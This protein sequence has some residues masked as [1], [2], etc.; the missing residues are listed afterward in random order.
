MRTILTTASAVLVFVLGLEAADIPFCKQTANYTM[1]VSL[2]TE[3]KTITAAEFIT[4]TNDTDQSTDEL[5][6]HLYW[7]AFQ[8]NQSTFVRESLN[9]GRRMPDLSQDDWGYCLVKSIKLHQGAVNEVHDLRPTLSFRHPDDDNTLDQTVFSVRLPTPVEPGQTVQIEIEFE[10]KIPKPFSRTGVYKE[11]YFI[12]QWFPKLGVFLDGRWNCHQY[13]AA[14]EYFADY[15]TYDIRITVPSAYIVGATGEHREK[16]NNGDGTTTH[17]FIQHSVH[18]FAWTASPHFLEFKE[19]YEFVPEK[20]VEI[21]LL[22]QP[23][24]KHL[25]PRYMNAIKNALTSCS[26]WYGDYPYTTVTCVDPAYNSRSGGMEYPTFFTGGAYF[27]SPASIA[28]PE[29]VTIHEF[30]HGYFYGL[31]GTNEFENPWM[32]EGF[33]SF[34]DTEV[35]YAAYGEPAYSRTFFG[36]PVAFNEVRIPIEADGISAHRQTF[37]R[38]VMQRY[39]WQFMEGESYGANSYS[40]AELMLRTLKRFLGQETYARLIKAYGERFWF[41]HPKPKDFFDVVSEFAGQDM[42]WFFDQIVY[43]SGKVDYAVERILNRRPSRPQGL[44]EGEYRKPNK[45]ESE[46]TAYVSEILIRRK[47]EVKIPVEVLIRF[48]GGLS[49]RETWDGQYRWTKLTYTSPFRVLSAVVDPEF[50]LVLDTN[51]T[52]NSRT[53]KP[54]RMAP[55]KWTSRWLVWLQHALEV[56]AILGG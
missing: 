16:K 47:G 32:D 46:E 11:Y 39:A 26:L 14:S 31:I 36:I 13:H 43:G 17:R 50:K 1:N 19:E 22:L 41:K 55:F 29:G 20:S 7:N 33:T 53:I 28:R 42:S 49:V 2:D 23:Y 52:N 21:T 37:D 6:F 34:L 8:N 35:Y 38:D 56:F 12:A 40:K 27:I 4:W 24:H 15:G 51:R 10:A 3:A 9:R 5:W 25:L 44:F 30:G 54:Q 18:D 48:E 45:P